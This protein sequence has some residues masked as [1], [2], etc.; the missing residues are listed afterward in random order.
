MELKIDPEFKNLIPPLTKDEYEAL[1]QSLLAEGCKHPIE[2]WND[3]IVDGHNR[4]EICKKHGIPFNTLERQ[5]VDKNDAEI[6]IIKN[7]FARRN[8]S[9]FQKAELTLAL[10]PRIAKKAK[11]NQGKRTD[12]FYLCPECLDYFPI[13][14]SHCLHCD[15]HYPP[16]DKECGNC[17]KSL[18]H[19]PVAKLTEKP[20][21]LG[22]FSQNSVK[23]LQ[24]ID[25]QKELARTAG[26]SH[27][28]IHKVEKIKEKAIPEVIEAARSGDVSISA[29][30]TISELPEEEQKEIIQKPKKERQQAVKGVR[31]N[32]KPQLPPIATVEPDYK[33][34]EIVSE[35][36]KKTYE[37]FEREVLNA[38]FNKWQTTSKEAVLAHLERLQ[39]ITIYGG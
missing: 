39:N 32:K 4:Y 22:N 3:V 38:K 36:F 20:D 18:K 9:D 2:T 5:F 27:D 31:K 25:T 35:S 14:V 28:T 26:V 34:R 17:H 8:L 30:S 12:L 11:E 10:K 16:E 33:K 6:W 13:K 24:P 37:A 7:Q 23:S 29:A 1:E 15:H 19:A 21:V